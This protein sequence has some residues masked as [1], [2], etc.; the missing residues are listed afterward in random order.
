VSLL[1]VRELTLRVA[2]TRLLHDISFELAAGQRCGL[3]GASG[4]GKS[5]LLRCLLG[6]PP[7][8]VR[9]TGELSWRGRWLPAAQHDPSRLGRAGLGMIFQGAGQALHPLRRIGAQLDETARLHGGES[10]VSLLEA[11]GLSPARPYLGRRPDQLS[12][13][14]RQRVLIALALAAQPALLLADE[15]T[16]SLDSVARAQILSLL[17]GLCA[18][19]GLG[20]LLVAHDPM[21]VR[22][23]CD[24]AL[25]L[26]DGELVETGPMAAVLD[27]PSH[28]WTRAL[29][30]AS[31]PFA[32]GP[33]SDSSIAARASGSETGP[34]PVLLGRDLGYRYR[35][36]N[37]FA[38]RPPAAFEGI[39]LQLQRGERV[40][41]LGASG[42]GKST[43]ARGLVG[44][45]PKLQGQLC[46][47]GRAAASLSAA[48]RARAIQLVLQDPR[49][50]LDPLRSAA[51]TLEEVRRAH[52]LDAAAIDRALAMAGAD[53]A[54]LPRRPGQLSGGQR[55]R[56]NLAR[57]LL[58]APSLLVLDEGLSALDPP[59]RLELIER[60]QQWSEDSGGA[61]L[62]I[63]H[64]LG[65]VLRLCPRT[66][67]LADG[68]LVEQGTTAELIRGAKHPATR[69]LVAAWSV[70]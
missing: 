25:V 67:V 18:E 10:A 31:A 33:I 45:L 3:L 13:G 40:A 30:A 17:Q 16:A 23:C 54:W 65:E 53:P 57:A 42:S 39:D 11:V 29:V 20:L 6:L 35:R 37:L 8:A 51:F 70:E 43:L 58:L 60:L 12:G 15:P 52:G 14:Q 47:L 22:R 49:A 69:A 1:A 36:P 41:L 44:L 26:A 28:P 64:D 50:A 4:S 48:E 55:Q 7:A 46:L 9:V 59:L 19:R 63:S 24:S 61:L 27:R 66:L 56:L 5:L 34:S 62:L 32:Q 38:P 68:R 21:L 2:G